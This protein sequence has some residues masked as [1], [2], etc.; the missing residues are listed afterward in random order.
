MMFQELVDRSGM[1]VRGIPQP[2]RLLAEAVPLLARRAP[3]LFFFF[4]LGGEDP[5]DHAQKQYLR[6]HDPHPLVEQVMRIHVTEE[7]RHISFAR[8]YLKREVPKMGRARR[9]G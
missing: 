7:A 2:L 5:I 4:V 3:A 9:G 1:D 8:T 6:A